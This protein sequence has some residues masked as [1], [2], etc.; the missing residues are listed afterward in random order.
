[1]CQENMKGKNMITG[2]DLSHFVAQSLLS[3]L[4]VASIIVQ[5]A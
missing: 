1:M 2:S 3:L 4:I 5:S